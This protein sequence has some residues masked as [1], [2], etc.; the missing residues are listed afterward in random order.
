M[1]QPNPYITMVPQKQDMK[2]QTPKQIYTARQQTEAIQDQVICDGMDRLFDMGFTN[3]D[4]NLSL[5][6]K[7]KDFGMAA[8]HLCVHGDTGIVLNASNAN[9]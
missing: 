1:S 3:Y 8:E 6:R 4:A 5:L 9:K 2:L 7:Y